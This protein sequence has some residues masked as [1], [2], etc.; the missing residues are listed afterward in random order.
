MQWV[1]IKTDWIVAPG[2]EFCLPRGGTRTTP[3][4]RAVT[5]AALSGV[6]E[7]QRIERKGGA[8]VIVTR[9]EAFHGPDIVGRGHDRDVSVAL[10]GAQA[11]EQRLCVNALPGFFL[12]LVVFLSPS[13]CAYP[14]AA[15]PRTI[16]TSAATTLMFDISNCQADVPL[17]LACE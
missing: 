10:V 8:H 12:R 4:R 5:E 7:R 2:D 15:I 1:C 13:P 6:E 16:P 3:E 14:G 9:V 11:I 17:N